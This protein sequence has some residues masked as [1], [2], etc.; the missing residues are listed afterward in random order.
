MLIS[1]AIEATQDIPAGEPQTAP[2]IYAHD[3]WG[4]YW[5]EPITGTVIDTVK[6]ERR[7]VTFPP[8]IIEHMRGTMENFN[9]DPAILDDVLPVVANEFIYRASD[10]SVEQAKSEAQEAIDQL[11]LFGQTIP[12]G[13]GIL[14]VAMVGGGFFLGRRKPAA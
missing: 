6:Y 13:M 5:V 7:T 14:G 12:L 11:T 10:E 3:F 8:E 2:L 9:Q 1:L 4:E